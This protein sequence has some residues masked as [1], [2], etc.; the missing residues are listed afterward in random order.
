MFGLDPRPRG[1]DPR[2]AEPAGRAQVPTTKTKAESG[3]AARGMSSVT[4][5]RAV[6]WMAGTLICFSLVGVATRELT[7]GAGLD[8]FQITF[9]RIVIGLAIIAPFILRGGWT[10]IK[11][12]NLRLHALRNLLLFGATYGWYYGITVLP[13][14]NVFALEF[15]A[16]VWV[17][18]LA[19]IFLKERMTIG[20]VVAVAF[21][22]VGTL[23]ILRPG[24]GEFSAASLIVLGS[25]IGL[26]C[27]HTLAKELSRADSP[28]T[29]MFWTSVMQGPFAAIPAI[30]VW[31]PMDAS[32]WVWAIV[33]G[34]AATVAHYCLVTALSL[35]DATIVIPMDFLRVPLIAVVGF[36]VYAE[37]I[38][39]WVI[40][41]AAAIFAGN[42]YNLWREQRAVAVVS[43]EMPPAEIPRRGE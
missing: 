43:V 16:P 35:A 33:M 18:V 37:A 13:L 10:S 22:I 7:V 2:V 25:A 21:G 32:T 11:T 4:P 36:L 31:T 26:A 23:V 34:S 41:G 28:L 19:V 12:K 9:L 20:R 8:I 24:V 38:D 6:P 15:T 3:H 30:V 17:A 5:F 1:S 27:S 40:A 14:A 39:I 29:L 42:Y